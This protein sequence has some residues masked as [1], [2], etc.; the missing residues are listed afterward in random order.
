MKLS[1]RWMVT[2]VVGIGLAGAGKALA[3][4][5]AGALGRKIE[6][7]AL[8]DFRGKETSLADLADKKV[9]VVAFL[10]NDCP[11]ARMY[12]AKLAELEKSL[13]RR[14]V[15]FLAINANVQDSLPAIAGFARN[16]KIEFPILKDPSGAVADR[17]GAVR[18]PEVFVLDAERVVRYQGR[19]DDQY[20]RGV[21]KPKATR[22]DLV[23]AI[24]DLLAGREVKVPQTTAIGCFISRPRRSVAASSSVT[25]SKH[26]ARILQEKCIECHRSGEVAPFPLTSYEEVAP[27]GETIREVVDSGRMPPWF[28]NPEYG[29]FLH[30]GR[31][32]EEEKQ[33]IADW[34]E[35]GCPEG[36][37]KD[38]PTP[39]QFVEGWGMPEPDLVVK[40]SD[41]PFQVPA[42]GV[43]DYIDFVVDPGWKED[44]WL[45]GAEARPGN[46][47]VVH[48]ILV[49][50]KKPGK[51][52]LPG[53][54]G[55]L[56]A[57][58]APGMKPTIAT[59]GMGLHAPAGSKIVFQMHY[60]PNGTACEDLSMAGF[61]YRDP[62]DVKWEVTA[63][64][65]I[66]LLFKIP[67]H[68]DDFPVESSYTFRRDA[69]VLGVNPHMHLRG[70][71][72]R[73]VA[74]YPDGRREILMDCPKFDF[75]WQI[76]Y[77]YKQPIAIPKGTRLVCTATYDNTEANPNNPDP[78]R[79]V[80]FGEQTWDEMMIG[81]FFMAEKREKPKR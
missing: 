66:N 63:G 47:A 8:R 34:V 4:G 80:T 18:V 25:Y 6:N 11:L 42:T 20:G 40:M 72:F 12:G 45:C 65:A 5:P 26:I 61:L 60:T 59:E 76:G 23:E 41:K 48:H 57:A 39:R 27:W 38:L 15:G 49:F 75:N 7:F 17:F 14:G 9:V 78:S 68:T 50:L 53:L 22:G 30:E 64:M 2:V 73:Y 10:G 33:S 32:S 1:A 13:G 62:E 16:H 21:V 35:A 36:D 37:K 44:K 58:Y 71:T 56:I 51:F 77:Q 79:T 70:K 54:P 28:A 43:M 29:E 67:P 46:R 31:L 24:E 52:Y 3:E 19:V 81:W 74:H 55:E 69:I